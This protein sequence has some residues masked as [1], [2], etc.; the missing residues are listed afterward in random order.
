MNATG[1]GHIGKVANKNCIRTIII[2]NGRQLYNIMVS[3]GLIACPTLHRWV[4]EARSWSPQPR[5]VSYRTQISSIVQLGGTPLGVH[6]PPHYRR[7]GLDKDRTI[8]P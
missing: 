6:V 2:C 3:K 8:S 7:H 1:L 5:E 4:K